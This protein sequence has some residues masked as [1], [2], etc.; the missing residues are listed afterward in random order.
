MMSIMD[1]RGCRRGIKNGES[2][3]TSN[4]G[5]ARRRKNKTKAQ[6]MCT[7]DQIWYIVLSNLYKEVTIGR[8]NK[9]PYKT[10]DLLRNI[11]FIR[12]FFRQDTKMWPIKYRWLLNRG[13]RMSR[14]DCII[15]CKAYFPPIHTHAYLT[16]QCQGQ[17][18]LV[19]YWEVCSW[20]YL[21]K[22]TK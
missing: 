20:I 19:V 9:W 11:Q 21:N 12:I 6:H 7:R 16:L 3:E 17:W 2:K 8:K 1:L 22:K 14:F 10:G 5:Y 18:I 13:D 15:K 4:I